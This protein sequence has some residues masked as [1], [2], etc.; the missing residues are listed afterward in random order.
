MLH[1]WLSFCRVCGAPIRDRGLVSYEGWAYGIH[2]V[3]F[4]F[5]EESFDWKC[6]GG[7][8]RFEAGGVDGF[9]LAGK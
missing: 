5:P 7:G 3:Q 2:R 6:E 9:S 8:L 4:S 1:P